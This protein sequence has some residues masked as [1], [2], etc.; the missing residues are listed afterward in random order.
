MEGFDIMMIIIMIMIMILLVMI[1]ILYTFLFS[2][3]SS[4]VTCFR[5]WHCEKCNTIF[6]F[7]RNY[8]YHMKSCCGVNKYKCD[9]CGNEYNS[10]KGLC[11]HRRND[12]W[13]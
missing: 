13:K 12:A 4:H 9:K 10:K 11:G 1:I 2:S 7:K 8:K 3:C 6:N 5:E